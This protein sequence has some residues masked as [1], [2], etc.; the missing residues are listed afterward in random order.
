MNLCVK[1]GSRDFLTLGITNT[2]L[3]HYRSTG[4]L[5]TLC[6]VLHSAVGIYYEQDKYI[7]IVYGAHGGSR[8]ERS[9][10]VKEL[11]EEYSRWGKYVWK[12]LRK[13]RERLCETEQPSGGCG[14]IR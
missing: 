13:E 9:I 12:I 6:L 4:G 1:T 3:F 2:N 14:N 11:G 8:V 5:S 10:G 7:L